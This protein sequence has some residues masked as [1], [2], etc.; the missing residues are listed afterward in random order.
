MSTN[1][2]EVKL[3]KPLVVAVIS[4]LTTVRVLR[5]QYKIFFDLAAL[6]IAHFWN[7]VVYRTRTRA[8]LPEVKARK[9]GKVYFPKKK[10]KK[11]FGILW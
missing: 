9:P 1:I 6:K 7:N 10:T 2:T 11:Y 3:T 5:F 8:V 4:A